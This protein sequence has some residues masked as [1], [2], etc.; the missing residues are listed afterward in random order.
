MIKEYVC[1]CIGVVGGCIISL[2]GGWDSAMKALI[3]CM[4]IDY[5]SGLIVAGIF[6]KSPKTDNGALESRTGLKGLCRKGMVLF[7]VM[8]AHELDVIS[9]TDYVRN[10]AIIGFI[11]NEAISILEN[12][13][14]MG[15][16]LPDVI[17]KSIEMLNKKGESTYED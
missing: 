4:V 8:V 7:I 5:V 1:T 12:A 14:L 10:A 13:G 11:S 3:T 16:P 6:K 9:G 2:L 15:I 17:K